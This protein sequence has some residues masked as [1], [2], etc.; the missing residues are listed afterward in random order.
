MRDGSTSAEGDLSLGILLITSDDHILSLTVIRIQSVNPLLVGHGIL[1]RSGSHVVRN[2]DSLQTEVYCLVP[3]RV[4]G[5]PAEPAIT[6]TLTKRGT[7]RV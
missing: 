6:P 2:A 5:Y 3:C 1:T 4:L 7:T